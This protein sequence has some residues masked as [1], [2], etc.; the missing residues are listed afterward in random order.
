M[1]C[2]VQGPG[3]KQNYTPQASRH[4]FNE[5]EEVDKALPYARDYFA[6]VLRSVSDAYWI[7]NAHVAEHILAKSKTGKCNGRGKI[8]FWLKTRSWQLEGDPVPR[9]VGKMH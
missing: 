1:T 7:E 2:R 9:F 5:G 6:P 3:W 4:V 8:G